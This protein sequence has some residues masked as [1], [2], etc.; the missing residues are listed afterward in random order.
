M[1]RDHI[2]KFWDPHNFW[3]NRA[4]RFI[5]GTRIEDEPLLRVDHKTTPKWASPGSRDP[6]SKF[7]D[8]LWTHRAIRFKF[9]TRIEDAPLLH[10]A[11]VTWPNF[12]ICGPPY[13]FWINW[14][15][16]L[17]FGTEMHDVSFLRMNLKMTHNLSGRGAGHVTQYRKF[18]TPYNW[19]K[20]HRWIT[21]IL[22]ITKQ[23]I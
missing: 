2:S 16:C 13:D 14:P 20:H 6:I 22:T 11:W 18:W 5:F 15:I 19:Q 10:V 7:W 1:S 23:Q 17:K 3:T 21:C 12:K 8:P 4:I 9:G